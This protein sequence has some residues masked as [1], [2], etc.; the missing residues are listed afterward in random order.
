MAYG[1]PDSLE[2]I[3]LYLAD[4][5]RGRPTPPELIEEISA[6][7]AAIG[8]RSPLLEITQKQAAALELDLN[9]PKN[10]N[11]QVFIGMRHWKPYIRET[12]ARI[13]QAGCSRI[14]ALC[15]TPFSS[16][17]TTGAYFEKLEAALGEIYPD[18]RPEVLPVNAWYDNPMYIQALAEKV[19]QG[20]DC[21]D[22]NLRSQVQVIF[23]AHSLPAA[24]ASQGDPYPEQFHELAARVAVAANLSPSQWV[25]GYQSAG[26][27]GDR[28]LGP[29][30][31]EMIIQAARQGLQTI[32]VAPIGFL[33]D[34]VEILYDID[35]EARRQAQQQNLRLERIPSLND[36]PR[37]IQALSQI[38]LKEAHHAGN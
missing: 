27:S 37:F 21:F 15:M 8:G 32:L 35:I 30:L 7:Y 1:G 36:D 33:T 5:R 18:A 12:V 24:L 22:A 13:K 19:I 28:W 20:L 3:A 17:M 38:I 14:I 34:H 25:A 6:R 9:N 2:D 10:G 23:T 31:D 16:R 29:S 11:Y 26:A 4:V